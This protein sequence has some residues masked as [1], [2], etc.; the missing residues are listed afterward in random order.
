MKSCRHP[1]KESVLKKQER[2]SNNMVFG[3]FIAQGIHISAMHIP[4]MQNVLKIEPIT[5]IEWAEVL[6]LAIPLLIVM[7]LFKVVR[8]RQGS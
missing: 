4:F 2:D 5:I 7:E 8:R 3:V 1:V 6:I